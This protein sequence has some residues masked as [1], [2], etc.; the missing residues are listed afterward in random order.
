MVSLAD[1]TSLA[2]SF[3]ILIMHGIFFNIPELLKRA[4]FICASITMAINLA[5]TVPLAILISVASVVLGLLEG[6]ETR[7]LVRKFLLVGIASAG[8][9]S[10]PEIQELLLLV[11]AVGILLFEQ[12]DS[13]DGLSVIGL[14]LLTFVATICNYVN[15]FSALPLISTG[16]LLVSCLSLC[17]IK[18]REFT[19]TTL[20]TLF[21]IFI[22]SRL[23]IGADQL[24][25]GIDE[26]LIFT[27]MFNLAFFVSVLAVLVGGYREANDV[28]TFGL[29]FCLLFLMPFTPDELP[30]SRA[31]LEYSLVFVAMGSI[32]LLP[33][34]KA[35]DY[36][37]SF[38]RVILGGIVISA[39]A[40]TFV[41]VTIS[42]ASQLSLL[43]CYAGSMFYILRS[44]SP[45]RGPAQV[46]T[47]ERLPQWLFISFIFGA[48]AALWYILSYVRQIQS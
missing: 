29:L 24:S 39:S 42:R 40:I 4:L 48:L 26:V 47:R 6:A 45:N 5:E 30:A 8:N 38:L 44:I 13:I 28:K 7:S 27:Q 31:T 35:L 34:N 21:L 41:D 19:T 15:L 16:L 33:L 11:S 10:V 12:L 14:W 25:L 43:L 22:C 32:L 46:L 23:M 36:G 18:Y 1:S 20:A 37:T 9:W 2:I 3:S 17:W